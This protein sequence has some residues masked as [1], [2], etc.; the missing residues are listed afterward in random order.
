[1]SPRRVEIGGRQV[2]QLA[3]LGRA[4]RELAR[5]R[6]QADAAERASGRRGEAQR[7]ACG[8]GL[9]PGPPDRVQPRKS[10]RGHADELGRDERAVAQQH[11][12]R[13]PQHRQRDRARCEAPPVGERG[14][15]ERAGQ[16]GALARGVVERHLERGLLAIALGERG[17]VDGR[18]DRESGADREERR[19]RRGAPAPAREREQGEPRSRGGAAAGSLGEPRQRADQPGERDPGRERHERR[20]DE[21]QRARA[22]AV[23]QLVRGRRAAYEREHDRERARD[24]RHVERADARAP[25]LVDLGGEQPSRDEA[26]GCEP[27][28]GDERDRERRSERV[29]GQRA[30]REPRPARDHGDRR[31][32]GQDARD[33]AE[34]RGHA[35]LREREQRR[36]AARRPVLL[37]PPALGLDVPAQAGRREHGEREHQRGRLAA[38]EQDAPGRSGPAVPRRDHLVHG[39]LD[40]E[41][42]VAVL[43]VDLARGDLRHDARDRPHVQRART[44]RDGP[45]VAA[46]ERGERGQRG[47][48]RRRSRWRRWGRPASPA[49]ARARRRARAAR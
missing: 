42:G 33:R 40:G 46:E 30:C 49:R 38:D 22:G 43:Q 1:M 34:E 29:P 48:L 39:R 25:R 18:E 14:G 3:G 35:R 12:G 6:R 37:E 31:N 13:Q 16:A 15:A 45:R 7:R 27:A 24:R 20:Q 11:V 36:L 26:R 9:E 23:L 21:Q 2:G 32:P 5:V 44:Q 28:A 10:R 47:Q 17:A 19:G 41:R 8:R 4:D